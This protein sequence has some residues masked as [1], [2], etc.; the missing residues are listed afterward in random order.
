MGAFIE[1]PS[2]INHKDTTGV[3]Q[4]GQHAGPHHAAQP[5]RLPSA[6]T[7]QRL[8]PTGSFQ[9]SLL[10]QLP[11]G[12]ARHARRYA[13]NDGTGRAAQFGSAE[14]LVQMEFEYAKL[15]FPR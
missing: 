5:V 10:G 3:A 4:R 13:V 7:Q 15:V 11:T 9:P 2:L 8:Q 1:K 6:A 14:C 12:L